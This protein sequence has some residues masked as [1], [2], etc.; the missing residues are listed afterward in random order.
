M[1]I[2]IN[3]TKEASQLDTEDFR[4]LLE[5]IK[6]RFHFNWFVSD[7]ETSLLNS[8]QRTA[9]TL[10]ENVVSVNMGDNNAHSDIKK[11]LNKNYDN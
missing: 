8:P 6:S 5:D 9:P 10:K 3:F 4:M 7:G 2:V 11:E 1:A